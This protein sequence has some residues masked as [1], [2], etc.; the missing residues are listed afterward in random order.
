MGKL[1]LAAGRLH[2]AAGA[3]LRFVMSTK[4]G[5]LL[6]PAPAGRTKTT[7]KVGHLFDPDVFVRQVRY[8]GLASTE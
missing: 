6:T 8:A 2:H 1:R 5:R 3:A 7:A 4:V